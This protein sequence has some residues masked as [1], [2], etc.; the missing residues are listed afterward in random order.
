MKKSLLRTL[1]VAILCCPI[2]QCAQSPCD[3]ISPREMTDKQ[4]LEFIGYDTRTM[5][6]RDEYFLIAP[7]T[8]I[9]KEDLPELRNNPQTRM[10]RGYGLLAE[11]Y[12]TVYLNDAG[13]PKYADL[14]AQA[15]QEWNNVSASNIRFV[16]DKT[17]PL[18]VRFIGDAGGDLFDPVSIQNPDRS[19]QY[20]KTVIFN[21]SKAL[22][23]L[24]D[25]SRGKYYM[26]HILGHL[27]GFGH[28]VTDP[29]AMP[30]GKFIIGTTGSDT[31]SIMRSENDILNGRNGEKWTGFSKWDIK[32]IQFLYPP[33]EKPRFSLEC[34]PQP[35]GTD[36]LTLQ[37]GTSYTFT[38]KYVYSL[39]PNPK[40]DVSVNKIGSTSSDFEW[41]NSGNG[42]FTLNFKSQGSYKIAVKVTNASK[43][44]LIEKTY[45]VKETPVQ[46]ISCSP[47]AEGSDKN[48]LIT[49][50]AY[51][52]TALYTHSTCPSP[53]YQI[54]IDK[55]EGYT[56][57][58]TENGKAAIIFSKG[59]TYKISVKVTN[60]PQTTQ[61]QKTYIVTDP[62]TMEIK[63]SPEGEGTEQ[64]KLITYGIYTFSA[65]YSH[66]EC[67]EPRYEI[68]IDRSSD[69]QLE[70]YGNGVMTVRFGKTGTYL[71]SVIVTNAPIPTRFEKTYTVTDPSTFTL[72]CSPQAEG[73]GKDNLVR[74]KPYT[75]TASYTHPAFTDPLY[76]FSIE[77]GTDYQME[78]I[79]NGI[80]S[81]SF[82]KGGTYRIVAKV[83]NA[84][85]NTI[86]EKTYLVPLRDSR[87]RI[88]GPVKANTRDEFDF[89]VSY[90][91]PD[92]PDPE[93]TIS[94][95][96]TIFN[97]PKYVLTRKNKNDFTLSFTEPG[98]YVV[99]AAVAH[100]PEIKTG[101]YFAP[102]FDD[103]TYVLKEPVIVN[104]VGNL[105][106][107]ATDLLLL[108][109]QNN[110]S[111][112]RTAFHIRSK[113][114]TY[115][116]IR[117]IRKK[118]DTFTKSPIETRIIIREPFSGT[119]RLP[120]LNEEETPITGRGYII[121]VPYYDKITF[122][123][124]TCREYDPA[125]DD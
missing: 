12:Q 84:P 105:N 69:Y 20:A 98:C 40:Y 27:V 122:P 42:T 83:T 21:Y 72:S 25:P 99:E 31:E 90:E 51:T 37:A 8:V 3:Q 17:A 124:N 70:Y 52:F 67:P 63:C 78:N 41:K 28:A 75:F 19:G 121:T 53:K 103:L 30:D 101:K 93:F 92:Y 22:P 120:H 112:T 26:M 33:K 38:A 95:T 45:T 81:V 82:S 14:L 5:I 108:E 55:T 91:N 66:P 86:C 79:R 32:A 88:S 115:T 111:Q 119:I 71:V 60:A 94:V 44:N 47:E 118:V 64:N 57:E 74:N 15:V 48:Q 113:T 68:A 29:F 43:S 13:I 7:N 110:Y 39:C 1:I 4:L 100:A 56:L 65:A 96:E 85:G 117:D 34:N 10:Q 36:A 16:S 9:L 123:D 102:A 114:D 62:A 2:T 116:L 35:T 61:F 50:R 76:E 77:N 18:V 49:Q 97:D 125:I 24:S 104:T 109:G 54:T 11:E 59:G 73:A 80:M 6:E 23:L 106:E 89:H 58:N 87:I 46:R 107:Y